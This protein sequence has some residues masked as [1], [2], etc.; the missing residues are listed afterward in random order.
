MKLVERAGFSVRTVDVDSSRLQT[1]FLRIAK[2]RIPTVRAQCSISVA[3]IPM[4]A[5]SKG[6]SMYFSRDIALGGSD[7]TS[8]ISRK[9]G[10]DQ[11]SAEKLK[12]HPSKDK[13]AD[14]LDCV[15]GTFNDLLDEVKL[16]F[17]YYE[18]PGGQRG[19]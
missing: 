5:Y 3:R 15:K 10:I 17:G 7:F 1:L 19:R 11:E 16:S 2:R 6:E 18:K 13:E 14:V 8:A 12:L 4:S 9:L